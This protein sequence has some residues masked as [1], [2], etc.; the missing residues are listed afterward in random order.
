MC[1]DENPNTSTIDPRTHEVNALMIYVSFPE[2]NQP[3]PIPNYISNV[4]ANMWDYFNEMSEG[5]HELNI[6]TFRRPVPNQNYTYVADNNMSYYHNMGEYTGRNTLNNELLWK[7]YNDDNNVF[8]DINVIF[9]NY[10]ADFFADYSGITHNVSFT[11]YNGPSTTQEELGNQLTLEWHIGHEYGNHVL[12]GSGHHSKGVYC[13][14]GG[15]RWNHQAGAVPFCTAHLNELGWLDNNH[16]ITVTTNSYDVQITDI[17]NS[18]YVYKIQVNNN[19]YFLIENHQQSGYD[20]VYLGTGLV[21]WHKNI[22]GIDAMDIETADGRYNWQQEYCDDENHYSFPFIQ[23]SENKNYGEDE[24]DLAYK[25]CCV[26]GNIETKSHPD[27]KGDIE[28]MFSLQTSTLF[29]PWTN[30]SSNDDNGIFTDIMVKVKSQQ[31]SAIIADLLINAPPRTPKQFRITGGPG[32]NPTARW[33]ANNE[34]DIAGYHVYRKLDD[35]NSFVLIYTASANITSYT[36][37]DL[38]INRFSPAQAY[39]HI[40]AFDNTQN[41]S[42]PTMNRWV[43]YNAWKNVQSLTNP[44]DYFPLHIGDKWQYSIT[45]DDTTFY[46]TK[47]VFG[48][49]VMPNGKRYFETNFDFFPWVRIDTSENIVY[50]ID[51]LYSD[52][53]QFGELDFFKLFLVDSGTGVSNNCHNTLIEY[54]NGSMYSSLLDDTTDYIEYEW[55]DYLDHDYKLSK[56]LGMTYFFHAEGSSGYGELVAAEIDGVT[57][58]EFVGVEDENPIP[59]NFKLHRPYPNPFNPVTTIRFSVETTDLLSLR[60]FD[61][62]GRLVETLVDSKIQVGEHEA[63]WNAGSQPSGVYFVRLQSETFF[64]TQKVLLMK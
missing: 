43:S 32:D 16:I 11:H 52:T 57:Y 48:D 22:N 36:D 59:K 7:V 51:A 50:A 63:V 60:V 9:F 31:G 8:N 49:T 28:D 41:K 30:P 34:P 56:H 40:T 13:Q 15:T 39:Y 24:I 54:E 47:Q 6:T 5:D 1:G 62:N 61:L 10:T 17:R 64:E 35:Q 27:M 38:I 3:Y 25:N 42:D 45:I 55:S 46:Q 14:R 2:Q 23:L 29:A 4:E 37:T 58:G 44:T 20:N 18:G 21:I 12:L 53:C 33:Q 19:E 26:N